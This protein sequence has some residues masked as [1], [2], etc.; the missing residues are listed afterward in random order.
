MLEVSEKHAN[1]IVNVGNA[2]GKDIV[3]LI[4]KVKK[5]VKNKYNVNLKLEQ[6]I[7]D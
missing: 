2:K 3:K 6:I 1:F 7:I 4:K 5:E